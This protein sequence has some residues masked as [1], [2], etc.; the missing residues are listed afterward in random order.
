MAPHLDPHIQCIID[1]AAGDDSNSYGFRGNSISHYSRDSSA[2]EW[3]FGPGPTQSSQS[4]SLNE[5]GEEIL[6]SSLT[7]I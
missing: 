1:N 4:T 2:G 7:T 3:S 6:L 5:F